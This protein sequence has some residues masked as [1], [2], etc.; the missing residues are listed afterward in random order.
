MSFGNNAADNRPGSSSYGRLIAKA[1]A[2]RTARLAGHK[3]LFRRMLKRL[4]HRNNQVN[5]TPGNGRA[6]S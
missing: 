1:D 3:S 6:D 4:R 5:P 2:A